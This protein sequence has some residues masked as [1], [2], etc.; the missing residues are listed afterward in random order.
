MKAFEWYNPTRIVLGTNS[1]AQL[2]KFLPK[3]SKVLMLYGG[4]SIKSN[5]V[6]ESVMQA[7]EG[8]S[9]DEFGGIE[10]NPT[11]ETLMKALEVIKSKN[12]DFLLA[13]GGG[14]VIDGTKFLSSAAL[15][16]GDNPWDILKKGIR[17]EVGMPFGTVLTLPATGSEMNS[18]AVITNKSTSEKL[19]MGG[20]GLFPQFSLLNPEVIKSLPKR[21]LQNGIVDA[22][23]HVLEQ[24]CTYPVGADLQDRIAESIL[25][26]LIY[27]APKILHEPYDET[28]ASNFMYCCTMALNGQ[29][30]KGVPTDWATHMIGH[31]LTSK[32]DI[33][34]ARTLAIV[35]PQ[36]Y[37]FKFEAKK[38]KLAQLAER[39]FDI[40]E[41]STE[42]KATKAIE[43]LEKFYDK[44]EMPHRL[45][46]YT[47]GYEDID[48][49]VKSIFEARNWRGIGERKDINPDDVA[50]ILR[51][52]Y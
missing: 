24:Y 25:K 38:E 52:T 33:D 9:V 44:I 42:V 13:V 21:Q 35:M 28:V 49:Q 3:D 41:G 20:P 15:Y 40:T 32:F 46:D 19:G 5:G 6:Y 43:A 4:G 18:G 12:I 36:L 2:S 7:L 14:S 17:T 39:V 30:Q 22:M 26:S 48:Q 1:I 27:Q 34:H 51:M 11:Y 47:K 23:T 29:I 31:E 45:S 50:K 10:A 37:R 16:T 8:Y